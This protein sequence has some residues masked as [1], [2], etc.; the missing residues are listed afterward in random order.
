[1]FTLRQFDPRDL[2]AYGEMLVG[3]WERVA[4]RCGLRRQHKRLAMLPA[5]DNGS[6][7]NTLFD[8]L[9]KLWPDQPR[10]AAIISLAILSVVALVIV[11]LW[12]VNKHREE[13][14]AARQT[15]ARLAEIQVEM[16]DLYVKQENL[17][18]AMASLVTKYL[19]IGKD[20]YRSRAE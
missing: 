1:L 10:R 14:A 12:V 4:M 20:D 7:L 9:Q 11:Q 16:Y 13:L 3:A 5:G 18:L 2:E 15:N 17:D 6:V 8:L 19:A